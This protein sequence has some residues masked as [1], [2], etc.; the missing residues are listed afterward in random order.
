MVPRRDDEIG[1]AVGAF[2]DMAEKLQES[3]ER[4]VYLRQSASWQ[5]LASKMSPERKNSL[6]PIRL[7]VEENMAG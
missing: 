3:T 6:T 1:S 4:L 7:T 5:T 2:N